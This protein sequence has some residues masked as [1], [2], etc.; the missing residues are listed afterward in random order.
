MPDSNVGENWAGTHWYRAQAVVAVHSV[1]QISSVVQTHSNIKAVGTRH[2]FNDIADST[3]ILI[4]VGELGGEP[5]LD[6]ARQ[7]VTVPAGMSYG[8]LGRFLEAHG[9]AA[10]QFRMLAPHFRCRGLRHGNSRFRRRE[11]VLGGGRL[12]H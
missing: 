8:T 7:R 12:R 6:E 9:W 2:S 5:I 11:S 4:T 1:D 10:P 3:G